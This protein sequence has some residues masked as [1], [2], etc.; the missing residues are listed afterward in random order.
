M[1]TCIIQTSSC[2]TSCSRD[3]VDGAPVEFKMVQRGPW[4]EGDLA[5]MG[6][7]AGAMYR[8]TPSAQTCRYQDNFFTLFP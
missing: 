8:W 6:A 5:F 4:W 3:P 7:A 1:S 2:V